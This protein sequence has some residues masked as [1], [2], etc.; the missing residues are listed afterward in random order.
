MSNKNYLSNIQLANDPFLQRKETAK[1]LK[2]KES[3]DQKEELKSI[4][5]DHEIEKKQQEMAK[6]LSQLKSSFKEA[7]VLINQFDNTLMSI[8]K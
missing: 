8:K 5:I 4:L 3:L 6:L 1:S 2:Q 7:E